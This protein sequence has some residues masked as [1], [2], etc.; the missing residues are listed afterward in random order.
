MGL[1]YHDGHT[2]VT[3]SGRVGGKPFVL[4]NDGTGT[5]SGDSGTFAGTDSLGGNG[6]MS[7]TFSCK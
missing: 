7:A 4:G 6:A 2:P 1:V 3:V 5:I